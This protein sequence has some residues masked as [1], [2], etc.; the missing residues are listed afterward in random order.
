MA[1]LTVPRIDFSSLGDLPAVWRQNQ[2]DA[3]R[4]QT[5]ASLGQGG[6]IDSATLLKSGDL[7]LAQLG[8][9][10]RNRSADD[11]RQAQQDTFNRNMQMESLRLRQNADKR[12]VEAENKPP[13]NWR[14]RADG[15]LEPEPGGPADPAYISKI[16]EIKKPNNVLQASDKK[17]ITAAEDELPNLDGTI[18]VLK[19]A[20]DLND[21]TFTGY[22][23][24]ARGVIG[25]SGV[26]GANLLV[27][28]NAAMATREWGQLMSGEAIKTMSDQLKGATTDF[29]LKKFEAMMADP[30]VPP[31]IRGRMIERMLKLAERHRETKARRIE[32]L[33]GG[34]YFKPDGG[35][36]GPTGPTRQ[37]AQEPTAA[38]APQDAQG[39]RAPPRPGE[40]RDGYRYKGGNPGDP[41]NWVKQESFNDRFSSAYS[42]GR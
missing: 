37:I 2:Q 39:F 9:A 38:P 28:K 24:G 7:S 15:V 1:E 26:P 35:K 25:T 31:E 20:K 33:R 5:L 34:T 18:D 29:E 17:I 10:M 4:R 30:S 19:M 27:D 13:E 41:T 23:A 12:A 3:L 14:R 16:N 42:G 21:K 32:E 6:D 40:L 36:T 22:T 8:V 11:A